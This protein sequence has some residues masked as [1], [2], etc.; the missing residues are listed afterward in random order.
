MSFVYLGS[1]KFEI[2][3][4]SVYVR[5]FMTQTGKVS[6]ME[7]SCDDAGGQ[8]CEHIRSAASLFYFEPAI[9]PRENRNPFAKGLTEMIPDFS[10]VS[11]DVDYSV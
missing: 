3:Y 1:D 10:L 4:G 7:C 6:Q 8:P 2:K 5:F 11:I 9:A